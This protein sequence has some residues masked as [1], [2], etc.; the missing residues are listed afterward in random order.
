MGLQRL[1][2]AE[3]KFQPLT[4]PKGGIVHLDPEL[5]PG[6]KAVLFSVSPGEGS[7]DSAV[8]VRSLVTGEERI[9][10]S[11]G[12]TPKYSPT[13]HLV[14]ASGGSLYAVPFDVERLAVRGAG[15]KVVGNVAVT[16]FVRTAQYSFSKNGTLVFVPEP[17]RAEEGLFWVTRN[18]EA[19]LVMEFAGR[20]ATHPSLSPDGGH[21]AVKIGMDL[22]VLDRRTSSLRRLTFDGS[23]IAHGSPIWTPDSQEITFQSHEGDQY[24]LYSIRADGSAPAKRLTKSPHV[25]RQD[26]WSPDGRVLVFSQV[27][28]DW[29]IDVWTLAL[30]DNK[31]QPLLR[32][33]PSVGGEAFS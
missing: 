29:T 21:I 9:L 26:S 2:K 4:E 22:W 8:A 10:F 28:S 12:S 14:Y 31:V 6:E 7:E 16:P 11:G 19:K 24:N 32:G 17:A 15:I 3:T 20:R 13:G 25:Q 27:K 18:G 23:N 30:D 5:L 1:S 33:A